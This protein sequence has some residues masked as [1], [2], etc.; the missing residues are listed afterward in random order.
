MVEGFFGE[1]FIFN[2]KKDG[3][4]ALTAT[5]LAL[6]LILVATGFLIAGMAWPG[7]R[8]GSD[9]DLAGKWMVRSLLR[10]AGAHASITGNPLDAEAYVNEFIQRSANQGIERLVPEPN[11]TGYSPIQE[12]ADFGILKI[13]SGSGGEGAVY[14][15]G[16]PAGAYAIV[17]DKQGDFAFAGPAEAGMP[18]EIRARQSAAEAYLVVYS[19]ESLQYRYPQT[20][21]GI[22]SASYCYTVSYISPAITASAW[23]SP[24]GFEYLRVR[25]V[26]PLALVLVEDSTGTLRGAGWKAPADMAALDGVPEM[27]VHVT[28]MPFAGIVRVLEATAWLRTEI[29]GGDAFLYTNNYGE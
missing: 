16:L 8:M 29:T 1:R 19:A 10:N 22:L 7:G 18:L 5:A 27:Q 17:A 24:P 9:S 15:E 2:G 11:G 4:F 12:G 6:T 20:G 23:T 25:N 3:G 28:G 14:V 13:R 21:N 26:P